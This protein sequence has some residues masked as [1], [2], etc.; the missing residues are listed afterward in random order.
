[1]WLGGW[2]NCVNWN[3]DM[4]GMK[5]LAWIAKYKRWTESAE[6]QKRWFERV[7]RHSKSYGSRLKNK[8][9][10]NLKIQNKADR[11]K[12][13]QSIFDKFKRKGIY[14]KPISIAIKEY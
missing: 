9:T 5:G 1:M 4:R 8:V 13:S 10:W 3:H 2:V 6:I 7:Y 14:R 12:Y 11:K